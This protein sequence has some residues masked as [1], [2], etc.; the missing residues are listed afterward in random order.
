MTSKPELLGQGGFGCVVTNVSCPGSTYRPESV[1]S[2]L[3]FQDDEGERMD[4]INSSK[5]LKRMDPEGNFSVSMIGDCKVPKKEFPMSVKKFCKFPAPS[6]GSL[7]QLDYPFA[8]ISVTRMLYDF[9]VIMSAFLKLLGHLHDM[10]DRLKL[11]HFDLKPDNAVYSDRVLKLVDWS[12]MANRPPKFLIEEGYVFYPPE[13]GYVLE[14]DS[15]TRHVPTTK[16]IEEW[17]S[18]YEKSLDE[19][20]PAYDNDFKRD[21]IEHNRAPFVAFMKDRNNLAVFRYGS[22]RLWQSSYLERIDSFGLG[23]VVMRLI[24]ACD[25]ADNMFLRNHF[26]LLAAKLLSA[27]PSDTFVLPDAIAYIKWILEVYINNPNA[28]RSDHLNEAFPT[29]PSAL[30]AKKVKAS[31]PPKRQPSKKKH[32]SR[33]KSNK[34]KKY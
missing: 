15:R 19:A 29:L 6:T 4:E 25:F 3:L 11:G 22:K 9:R 7:T 8:G 14:N 28:K 34:S 13:T 5:L 23:F 30:I 2:K 33:S 26:R 12:T 20:L 16:Q 18:L 10:H 24:Q 17:F 32:K 27:V 31:K 21:I 1:A